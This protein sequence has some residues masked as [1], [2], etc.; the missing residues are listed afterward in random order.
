MPP[1]GRIVT[2]VSE[3]GSDD[4]QKVLLT[5]VLR[6]STHRERGSGARTFLAGAWVPQ[7]R[8]RVSCCGNASVRQCP[9]LKREFL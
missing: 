7:E 1:C 9:T 3:E 4:I 6:V 8:E 2:Q 5:L